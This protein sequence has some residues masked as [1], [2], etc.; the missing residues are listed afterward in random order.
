M[1]KRTKRGVDHHWKVVKYLGDMAYYAKCKCG[2]KYC[3]GSM[4]PPGTSSSEY[5]KFMHYCPECG[6][7]KKWYNPEVIQ[8]DVD[9]FGRTR[10]EM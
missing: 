8:L 7:K 4:F 6:A 10:E 2:Y 5:W 1:K 9:P 3:C